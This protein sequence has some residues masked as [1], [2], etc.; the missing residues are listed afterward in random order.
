MPN[1]QLTKQVIFGDSVLSVS[2]NFSVHPSGDGPKKEM[3]GKL[4]GQ[5]WNPFL[6][7]AANWQSVD[8]RR[9]VVEGAS[10]SRM[11]YAVPSSV[12]A[13]ARLPQKK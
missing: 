5:R 9:I 2:Q 4:Y 6:R 12:V 11:D 13:I 1:E 8:A 7:A 3:I 10:V